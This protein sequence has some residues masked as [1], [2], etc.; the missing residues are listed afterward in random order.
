MLHCDYNPAKFIAIV[1]RLSSPATTILIFPNSKLTILGGK[2]TQDTFNT[3]NK[4]T[5]LLIELGFH[6]KLSE[7]TITNIVGHINLSRRVRLEN[8]VP[9]GG[10]YE[11]ELFPAAYL[12][13]NNVTC[14]IFHSGKI[15]FTGAKTLHQLE[16]TCTQCLEILATI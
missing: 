4:I 13:L 9:L 15:N 7:F 14:T 16:T 6:A 5:R 3:A 12:R 11:V 8:L 2:S 1:K 10:L